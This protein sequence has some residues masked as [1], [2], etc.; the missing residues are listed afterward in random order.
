MTIQ[1]NTDNAPS[2]KEMISEVADAMLR[3]KEEQELISVKT[4]L[5]RD[6]YNLDTKTSRKLA[7]I[8]NERNMGEVKQEAQRLEEIYLEIAG[9]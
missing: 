9:A 2:L 6:F 4:K 5:I 3:I 1:A 7:R 8:L